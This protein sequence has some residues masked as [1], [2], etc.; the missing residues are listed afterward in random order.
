MFQIIETIKQNEILKKNED[1]FSILLFEN[2]FD[3]LKHI[4]LFYLQKRK[5]RFLMN[6][7]RIIGLTEAIY[8]KHGIGKKYY[9]QF[10]D[11]TKIS[12][13]EAIMQNAVSEAHLKKFLEE[14]QRIVNENKYLTSTR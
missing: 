6:Y 4:Y 12:I 9:L 11:E 13:F 5:A 2:Y 8:K 3:D 1:V 10:Q 14:L 7:Y